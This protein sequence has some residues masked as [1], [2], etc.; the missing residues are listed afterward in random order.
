MNL[1]RG[2]S[3]GVFDTHTRYCSQSHYGQPPRGKFLAAG[4]QPHCRARG[5]AHDQGLD[6][7]GCAGPELAP[8]ALFLG[9]LQST[10]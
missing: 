5:G 4:D 9:A 8:Y 2:L 3:Q 7:S 6:F 10:C 1:S